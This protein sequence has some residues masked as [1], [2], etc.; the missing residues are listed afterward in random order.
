MSANLTIRKLAKML[1]VSRTTV[2]L[3]LNN[4]PR[5]PQKTRL[6]VQQ[7]AE[8]LGYQR[9]ALVTTLK[10]QVRARRIRFKGEV[11][12]FITALNE[13]FY[14]QKQSEGEVYLGARE[15]ANQLGFRLEPFWT[16]PMGVNSHSIARVLRAR[17]VRGM[18]IP[19]MPLDLLPL[20]LDWKRMPAVTTG[21]SFSQ[22]KLHR[23]AAN[24]F[25]TSMLCYKKL[26]AMGHR[27]IG[28]AMEGRSDSR[29]NYQW[30]S[31]YL[32]S[33]WLHGGA[34]LPP[35]D[36]PSVANED[37]FM[38]WFDKVRPDAIIGTP[39]SSL[40][41]DWLKKRGLRIPRDVSY[42]NLDVQ[43][44]DRDHV[45]GIS[46]NHHLIGAGAITLLSSMIFRNETSLPEHPTI[47]MV[48]VTWLDGGT[49]IARKTTSAQTSSK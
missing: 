44:E 13:E 43:P 17:G 7:L 18:V 14:W 39:K 24:Q 35:L 27:R 12:A 6:R 47:T 10:T 34:R 36:M 29:V 32:G 40:I 11:L 23:V 2:S 16:G 8:S 5:I 28:L 49:T 22:Q 45:S 42:V 31:A 25:Q 41:A 4:H 48:D 38:R 37:T 33:Q 20:E 15:M 30:G 3:S 9:N 19:Y 21:Y 46:Q 26:H 1:G